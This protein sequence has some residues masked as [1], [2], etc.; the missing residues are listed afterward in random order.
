MRSFMRP[1]QNAK[2]KP[3]RNQTYA[4]GIPN[5]WNP[6]QPPGTLGA[7]QFPLSSCSEPPEL[8]WP[9]TLSVHKSKQT[10][11][12]AQQGKAV[13]SKAEQSRSKQSTS[14]QSSS[15]SKANQIKASN[16]AQSSSA[17]VK[18]ISAHVFCQG[19]AFMEVIR[20]LRQAVRH[21]L[22]PTAARAGLIAGLSPCRVTTE[23]LLQ[24]WHVA[25]SKCKANLQYPRTGESMFLLP[26]GS[27][28]VLPLTLIPTITGSWARGRFKR[29]GFATGSSS[30][31]KAASSPGRQLRRHRLQEA[32]M[33]GML[34]FSG[35]KA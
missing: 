8:I 6:L 3:R 7:L 26:S 33:K 15:Q 23:C 13:Q 29:L 12:N 2:Q 17:H 19:P 27:L 21:A 10:K 9:E 34:L 11:I 35:S 25:L 22:L 5:Q 4:S 1:Q 28:Q 32:L 24:A 20:Q 16:H 18:R 14:K 31:R 30:P